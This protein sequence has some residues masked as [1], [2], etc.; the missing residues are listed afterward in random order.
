MKKAGP[1]ASPEE[2]FRT[3]ETSELRAAIGRGRLRVP[4]GDPVE[5]PVDDDGNG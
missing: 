1:P 4:G 3:L 5:D 2:T